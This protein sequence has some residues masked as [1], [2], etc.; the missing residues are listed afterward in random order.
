IYST[1]MF[2]PP[3]SE[4]PKSLL[5]TLLVR[6]G[7][8]RFA[9]LLGAFGATVLDAVVVFAGVFGRPPWVPLLSGVVL[10]GVVFAGVVFAGVVFV[11][12]GVVV[13]VV[14]GVVV[15]VVLASTRPKAWRNSVSVPLKMLASTLPGSP[16][17][18][19]PFSVNC[20]IAQFRPCGTFGFSS[21]RPLTE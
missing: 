9:P 8:L 7:A 10:V 3:R 14:F 13:F 1:G 4:K 21:P 18:M 16:W 11:V 2:L 20:Q 17:A 6:R 5:L 12:F 15:S 19:T